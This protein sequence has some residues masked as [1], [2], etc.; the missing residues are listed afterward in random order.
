MHVSEY[1]NAQDNKL[2]TLLLMKSKVCNKTRSSQRISMANLHTSPS[3]RFI[4]DKFWKFEIFG[5]IT[6]LNNLT[7]QYYFETFWY[8]QV[9]DGQVCLQSERKQHSEN[10][11]F[12]IEFT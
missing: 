12:I 9:Q 2:K 11:D 1:H 5:N 8:P 4:Q 10:L 3:L 6:M 7:P